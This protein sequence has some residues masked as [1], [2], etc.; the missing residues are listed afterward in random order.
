VQPSNHFVDDG[1]ERQKELP[2]RPLLFAL[3][4]R[5]AVLPRLF[6]LR[7]SGE[8]K[9]LTLYDRMARKSTFMPDQGKTIA[10]RPR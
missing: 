8:Y 7:I 3:F 9:V 2:I 5:R 1:S 10:K 6:I 4:R